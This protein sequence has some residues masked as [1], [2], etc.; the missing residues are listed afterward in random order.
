MKLWMPAGE[1][2][3]ISEHGAEA[4]AFLDLTLQLRLVAVSS[5]IHVRSIVAGGVHNFFHVVVKLH[6]RE[7]DRSQVFT[8]LGRALEVALER[9]LLLH[10]L[11]LFRCDTLLGF[12]FVL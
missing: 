2:V 9:V 3:K 5:R 7:E 11:T 10:L 1:K 12:I 6:S 4:F 8:R